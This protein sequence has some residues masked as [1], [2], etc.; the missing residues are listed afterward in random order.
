M[1]R[2]ITEANNVKN[3]RV[4]DPS[5][6]KH[7]VITAGRISDLSG[8]IDPATHINLDF[9]ESLVDAV[10]ISQ[11]LLIG[12]PV[13]TKDG[14]F[15]FAVID[16]R[17]YQHLGKVDISEISQKIREITRHRSIGEI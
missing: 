9:P 14:R 15:V 12:A 17:T 8:W 6:T 16:P 3:G 2:H 5:K 7:G 11:K 13:C 10:V 4:I 1:I